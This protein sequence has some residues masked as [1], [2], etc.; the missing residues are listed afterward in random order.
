M[1]YTKTHAIP[2]L[3]NTA[4]ATIEIYGKDTRNF[5]QRLLRLLGDGS[6]DP[7]AQAHNVQI[8][9]INNRFHIPR[10]VV[11]ALRGEV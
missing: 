3:L 4:Q 6:L 2:A 5:R 11:K 8:L 1:F 9:K 10:V 7:I